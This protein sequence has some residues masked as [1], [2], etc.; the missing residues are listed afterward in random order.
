[1]KC[2][3][4]A[5][6]G[7]EAHM[8]LDLLQQEGINTRIN[9]E[10]LQGGVGE[11]QAMNIVRVLVDDTDY[12]KARAI[13]NE[14]ESREVVNTDDQTPIKKSSGIGVGLVFGL[15]IGAGL[16]FWAYNSPITRDG[17]DYNN[18][19][20]LDEE[21]TYRD[22]R[23]YRVD[24]DRNLDG[25]M[26][27]IHHYNHKGI[28]Y[29]AQ[30]DD[31]FDGIYETKYRYKLG[32]VSLQESDLNLDGDIDYRARFKNDVFYEIEILDP[33]SN[34]P[35]KRQIYRMNKLVFAEYDSDGDGVY[36]I[37]YEYDYYEEIAKKKSNEVR[38]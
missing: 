22:N 34:Y 10:Y 32:N 13:I 20:Q 36:D 4:E 8:I 29:K 37:T 38:N 25:N 31:D 6:T 9:G 28:I 24:I 3:F 11:L 16:T 14:W 12:D 21:W 5:S 17:I 27:V 26:D 2:V 18:D 35:R 7:L 33:V 30:T 19:G 1:M 15:V 23:I